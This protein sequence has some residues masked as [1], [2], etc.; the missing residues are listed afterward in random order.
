MTDPLR[1]DNRL[2]QNM[3]S[4]VSPEATPLLQFLTDNVK[5]IASVIVG[6]VLIVAA[7]VLYQ[8]KEAENKAEAQSK[9]AAVILSTEGAGRIKALEAL[10][11]EVPAEL[12]PSIYLE[13]AYTAEQAQDDAKAAETWAKLYASTSDQPLKIAAA[14]GRANA[15]LAMNKNPEAI[16]VLE[17][18]LALPEYAD[19]K[20]ASGMVAQAQMSL[21]IAA[22]RV[23]DLQKSKAAYEA[24]LP[25]ATGLEKDFLSRQINMLD[26]KL[27]EQAPK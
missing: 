1:P 24:L 20:A 25:E 11:P 3:R 13:I 14:V 10:V 17:E 9:I 6:L 18:V 27:A 8:W 4:E 19:H 5:T 16:V 23:G 2:L 26:K 22:A 7:V 15:L 12:V 21:A